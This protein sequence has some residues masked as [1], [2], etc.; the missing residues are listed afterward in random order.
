[1]AGMFNVVSA[2]Y[3]GTLGIDRDGLAF[4]IKLLKA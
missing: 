4:N 2:L 1:M 3:I